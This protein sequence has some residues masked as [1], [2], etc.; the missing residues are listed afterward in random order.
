MLNKVLLNDFHLKVSPLIPKPDIEVS[1]KWF[2]LQM[3]LSAVT[4]EATEL[5]LKNLIHDFA[6]AASVFK[7]EL[8]Q[9]AYE[10][11]FNYDLVCNSPTWLCLC[12]EE[13]ISIKAL[14]ES[15]LVSI[16]HEWNRPFAFPEDAD[17]IRALIWMADSM[18]KMKHLQILSENLSCV[19]APCYVAATTRPL[20]G[21][22][23]SSL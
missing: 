12:L 16:W 17:E 20:L 6:F 18:K 23:E 13:G 2:E 11:G 3:E 9:T 21:K 14:I 10:Q 22:Q 15:E 1:L 8:V 5:F 19:D 4:G 7:P